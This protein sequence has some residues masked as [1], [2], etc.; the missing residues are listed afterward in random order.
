MD[1]L[2]Q[3][4]KSA[5]PYQVGKQEG[6]PGLRVGKRGELTGLCNFVPGGA[7][8]FRER[9]AQF[10]AQAGFWEDR[11]GT[12]HDFRM[13]IFDE[14]TRF[15][16]TICYDGDFHTYVTDIL[17]KAG[18]WFDQLF[19]GIWEGF[20]SANH[21]STAPLILKAAVTAEFFYV[22][23]PDVTRHDVLKMQKV[24]TAVQDLLEAAS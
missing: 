21:E 22:G 5:K 9:I 2:V 10:Q 14:D 20:V 7:K 6:G 23:N 4:A 1:D 19:T 16:F 24:N 12:V 8:I 17:Q 11:V 13:F 15:C 3:Q 18:P